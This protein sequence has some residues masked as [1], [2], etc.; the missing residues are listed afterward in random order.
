MVA[1]NIIWTEQLDPVV[2]GRRSREAPTWIS[3]ALGQLLAFPEEQQ[4]KYPHWGW[5][6]RDL[7]RSPILGLELELPA[8]ELFTLQLEILWEFSGLSM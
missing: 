2:G 3:A 4:P 5:V 1:P 8:L 6:S 7:R